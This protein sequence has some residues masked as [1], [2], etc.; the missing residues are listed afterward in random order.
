MTD[1]MD[2]KA[3]LLKSQ[4]FSAT[5]SVFK[6]STGDANTTGK[7]EQGTGLADPLEASGDERR[8]PGV[9]VVWPL[10]RFLFWLL[11]RVLTSA[12]QALAQPLPKALP[13]YQYSTISGLV[14]RQYAT[15]NY[16]DRTHPTHE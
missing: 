12:H 8:N 9:K 3:A 5:A 2:F 11:W 6:P 7:K 15:H 4:P 16:R 1:A 13:R 14:Q 10:S